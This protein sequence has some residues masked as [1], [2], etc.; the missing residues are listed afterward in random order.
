MFKELQA[1][2]E[3]MHSLYQQV[4]A[5]EKV[6]HVHYEELK[7]KEEELRISEKRFKLAIEASQ[8]ALWELDLV[9]GEFLVSPSHSNVFQLP[10]VGCTRQLRE[11]VLA[12][13]RA[14][15]DQAWQE[16]LSG[17]TPDFSCEFRL[18][19]GENG[20]LW[21]L[22]RA[23]TVETDEVVGTVTHWDWYHQPNLFRW[24]RK[25]A[26]LFPLVNGRSG[27]LAVLLLRRSGIPAE[28]LR[29]LSIFPCVSFWA[30]GSSIR[31]AAF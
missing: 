12:E 1:Q 22:S 30:T 29:Y 7:R 31:Y 25:A 16:Y 9:S 3:E 27:K 10:E 20:Y 18:K 6:L 13:D 4:V 26:L 23:R 2:T 15:C 21:V 14:R 11:L 19:D 24:Q 8:N 5:S 28:R 17:I